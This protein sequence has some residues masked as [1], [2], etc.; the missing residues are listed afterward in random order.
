MT[1]AK[2]IA[3]FKL[4]FEQAP[5]AYLVLTRELNIVA[6]SDSYLAATMTQREQILGQNIF[7]VFPDNP[8][9]PSATGSTNLRASLEFVLK[10]GKQ[11]TMAVQKYDVPVPGNLSGGFEERH[12]SPVNSPVFNEQGQVEFIIHRVE[13]VSEFVFLQQQRSEKSSKIEELKEHADLMEREIY[14]RAQEIQKHTAEIELMNLKLQEARDLALEA[15]RY[16]S[17]FLANM[18]HELLTPMNGILGMT[19]IVLASQLSPSI[20][21]NVQTIKEAGQTLLSVIN[22]ILDYTEIEAGR[23]GLEIEPLIISQLLQNVQI[24]FN[25]KAQDKSLALSSDIAADVPNLIYGDR[26]R[27][28]QVLSNL[29]DNAIRFSEK[30]KVHI[31]ISV[32]SESTDIV[33]VRFSVID[34]GCG[35][36]APEIAKLFQPFAQV[37]ASLTRRHGGAGLGLAIAK[38]QVELMSGSIGVESERSIGSNFWFVIPLQK[39]SAHQFSPPNIK[40][41]QNE[42]WRVLLVSGDQLEDLGRLENL[43]TNILLEQ[44]RTATSALEKLHSA[45]KNNCPFQF[46]LLDLLLEDMTGAELAKLLTERKLISYTSLILLSNANLASIKDGAT[47]L[48]FAAH[49]AKPIERDALLDCFSKLSQRRDVTKSILKDEL[50]P[51]SIERIIDQYGAEILA[52]FIKLFLENTPAQV[53]EM[54]LALESGAFEKLANLA[55]GLK[56]VSSSLFAAKLKGLCASLESA[57]KNQDHVLAGKCFDQLENEFSRICRFL[58]HLSSEL[59]ASSDLNG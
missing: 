12:W 9:D 41:S 8:D 16:N 49:L 46:L 47:Q 17:E 56:G 13:D 27:I 53:A 23:S 21:S 50:A 44:T 33:A 3:D 57:A 31:T 15:S 10:N 45:Q 2:K 59:C 54:K 40:V 29:T 4:L 19:D 52:T 30:G 48:G 7:S 43:P 18:S 42:E 14:L 5:Q 28:Q 38:L 58:K 1:K 39:S 25:Q 34:Q 24:S 36:S 20:R 11:H 51:V 32:D 37:D 35:L 22:N 6:V 26:K 55:H